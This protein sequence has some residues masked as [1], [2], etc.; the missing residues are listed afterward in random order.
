MEEDFKN[1]FADT[2]ML[3][4]FALSGPLPADFADALAENDD[5]VE[6]RREIFYSLLKQGVQL[7]KELV[8]TV[9][10]EEK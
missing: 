6:I 3:E 9:E 5:I 4:A 8:A 1:D 2:L 10:T 7:K